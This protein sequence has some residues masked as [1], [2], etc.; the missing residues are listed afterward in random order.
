MILKASSGSCV[1]CW[2]ISS[3]RS[4]NWGGRTIF[5]IGLWFSYHGTQINLISFSR[6]YKSE[7]FG[8]YRS[9]TWSQR[10]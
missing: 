3:M 5:R 7:V 8:A 10:I 9:T 2:T 6:P 4:F 1:R